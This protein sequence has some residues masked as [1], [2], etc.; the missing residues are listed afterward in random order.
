MGRGY[1]ITGAGTEYTSIDYKKKNKPSCRGKKKGVYG[2][3]KGWFG[4]K[5]AHVR[6][7]LGFQIKIQKCRSVIL[8]PRGRKRGGV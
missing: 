2:K 5:G 1:E 8:L 4:T 6:L 7:L 3:K